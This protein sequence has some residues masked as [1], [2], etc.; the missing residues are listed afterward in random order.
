MTTTIEGNV[1]NLTVEQRRMVVEYF[2]TKC[3]EE[4]P[5]EDMPKAEFFRDLHSE[6]WRLQTMKAIEKVIPERDWNNLVE[7]L[8]DYQSFD[9]NPEEYMFDKDYDSRYTVANVRENLNDM[10][11]AH[12]DMAARY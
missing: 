3:V 5:S 12:I 1:M 8:L 11:S 4:M 6:E 9:R 2:A 10:A 7:N